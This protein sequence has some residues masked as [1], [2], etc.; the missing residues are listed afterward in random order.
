MQL[1]LNRIYDNNLLVVASPVLGKLIR[2][3]V[4]LAHVLNSVMPKEGA[5][6][7]QISLSKF[8]LLGT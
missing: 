3:N 4:I 8:K 7:Q 5:A 6:F 2:T 1:K